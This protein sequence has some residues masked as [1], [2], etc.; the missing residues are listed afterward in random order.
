MNADSN[1]R[2]TADELCGI[3]KF[4]YSSI[5]G[6]TKEVEVFGY[7]G[8]EIKEAFEE[9][10]KEIPNISISYEKNSDAVY[11]SRAFAFNNLLP[12]PVNKDYDSKLIGLE[13]PNSIQLKDI[14]NENTVDN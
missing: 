2:P 10:D 9:A 5:N 6:N 4:W 3:F 7:K 1:K 14:D 13:I 11:T 12:E 8:K